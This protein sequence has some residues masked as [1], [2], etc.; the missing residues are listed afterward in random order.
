MRNQTSK[1]RLLPY[2]KD[3]FPMYNIWYKD[4]FNIHN[5][6]FAFIEKNIENYNKKLDEI[7][8][9]WLN[10]PINGSKF[11]FEIKKEFMAIADNVL[12]Q[13][14]MDCQQKKNEYSFVIGP[15]QKY[16]EFIANDDSPIDIDID[17]YPDTNPEYSI[18]E[19][20]PIIQDYIEETNIDDDYYLS[21]FQ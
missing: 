21:F 11:M 2:S 17:M 5:Q 15:F 20:Q 6:I 9:E 12:L 8:F 10:K 7:F 3:N 19:K 18:L 13:E 16:L 4:F 14:I 1:K